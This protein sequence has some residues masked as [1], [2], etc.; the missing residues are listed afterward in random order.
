[1]DGWMDG[2]MVLPRPK[3]LR[4]WEDDVRSPT[5]S[6]QRRYNGLASVDCM[7]FNADTISDIKWNFT[8]AFLDN[9][10]IPRP[11]EGYYVNGIYFG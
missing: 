11:S 7:I 9:W 5:A 6:K 3:S 8:L 2:S 10:A 4:A 1:M